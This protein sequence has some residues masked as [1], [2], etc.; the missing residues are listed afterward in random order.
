[1]RGLFGDGRV[2]LH[3]SRFR[4]LMQEVKMHSVTYISMHIEVCTGFSHEAMDPEGSAACDARL[5]ISIFSW[6]VQVCW[7]GINR[8]LFHSEPFL[9]QSCARL[10][11]EITRCARKVAARGS[12]NTSASCAFSYASFGL[13]KPLPY[14]DDEVI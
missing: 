12:T 10:P 4:L 13:M 2:P 5:V 6:G 14:E 7:C 9:K 11:A 8:R 3:A 1:M